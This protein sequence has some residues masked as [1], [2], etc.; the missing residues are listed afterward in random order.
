MKKPN[1]LFLLLDSLRSDKSVA[2]YLKNILPNI[3]WMMSKGTTFNN[4]IT[5]NSFTI[6]CVASMFTGLYPVTHGVR[7]MMGRK[8]PKKVHTLAE[9]FKDNGY[10]T[11]GSVVGP[12]EKSLDFNRGF[13]YFR[14]RSEQKENIYSHWID[15]FVEKIKYEYETPWFAYVHFWE[16]HQ[17]R[18]VMKKYDN[19][20]Y[21]KTLYE[22]SIASWDYAFSKILKAIPSN[23]LLILT[24][25]H[26]EV[27]GKNILENVIDRYKSPI[28][29]ALKRLGL[30]ENKIKNIA[31]FRA[32]LMRALRYKG[33]VKD[34]TATMIGH[35][36]HAYD[37]LIKVPFILMHEN[38]IPSGKII[39][40][41]VAQVDIM[42][43]IID[44]LGLSKPKN[45]IDGQ[46][47]KPLLL[48]EPFD[49]KPVYIEAGMPIKYDQIDAKPIINAIRYKNWKY[50]Y[51]LNREK[52]SEELYNLLH[53]PDERNNLIKKKLEIRNELKEMA[54][55][56]F[57][58]KPIGYE[59]EEDSQ[60]TKEEKE[61]IEDKLKDLGY[62]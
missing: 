51:S 13:D 29:D 2:P 36:H 3:H 32:N 19:S 40:K 24:G 14:M 37:C 6:P 18:Q 31:N 23:T 33:I 38:L 34:D 30:S 20:K 60:L 8:I 39:R 25:D 43:T 56:H 7:T 55:N 41:Q 62:M 47:L 35:G 42:P 16:I 17:P 59:K 27:I 45:D 15:K 26:G 9:V 12:L 53:D 28:R 54:K 49:E 21:G 46:S 1:V 57:V 58:K 10:N 22:R 50:I 61:S 48:G 5:V 11:Y 52:P 44:L 4:T